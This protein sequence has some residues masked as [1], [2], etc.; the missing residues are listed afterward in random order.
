[1]LIINNI[2]L[3]SNKKIKINFSDENEHFQNEFRFSSWAGFVPECKESAG[4]KMSTRSIT[5]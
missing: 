1:M 4:K 3:K 2:L 5:Y